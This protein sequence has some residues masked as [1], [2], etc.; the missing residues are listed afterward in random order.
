VGTL[1]AMPI[2]EFACQGCGEHFD[3]LQAISEA[4]PLCPECGSPEVSRLISLIAGLSGSDQGVRAS[5][6]CGCG[7][8][9]ACAN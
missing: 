2:Y 1:I 7:G 5:G 4:R 3:R 9:C 8:R 6:G